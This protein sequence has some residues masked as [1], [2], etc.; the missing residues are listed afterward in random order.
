MCVTVH[1][2]VNVYVYV[3]VCLC[4]SVD[5]YAHSVCVRVYDFMIFEVCPCVRA[6]M[7]GRMRPI[8]TCL[9]MF[10]SMS[11]CTCMGMGMCEGV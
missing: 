4:A 6:C 3:Y 11:T 1:V 9:H 8:C 7:Y 2:Y 10:T 5:V